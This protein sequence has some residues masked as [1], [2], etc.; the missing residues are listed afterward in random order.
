MTDPEKTHIVNAF[1]F[2][3]GNVEAVHVRKRM[4]GRLK[5]VQPELCSRVEKALG[6]E[7]Q[8]EKLQ[9]AAPVLDSD[10][11]PA[12]SIIGR[13][14]ETLEGRKIGV[15]VCDGTDNAIVDALRKTAKTEKFMV[16]VVAP[17]IGGAK[18][19]SGTIEAD[20]ALAAGPSFVFDAVIV[21]AAGKGLDALVAEADAV[22][23]VH[24]A[25]RH[26]KIIGYTGAAKKLLEKANIPLDGDEGLIEIGGK[27]LAPFVTAAKKHRIWSRESKVAS[28]G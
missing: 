11:S 14:P 4:L 17:K 3:L 24:D 8:A 27:K 26:C 23:W 19:T 28:P 1:A 10:P 13:L 15:L 12:L 25:Y 6:M 21:A 18:G 16:A 7:G 5:L 22:E 20:H 2:E 9:P